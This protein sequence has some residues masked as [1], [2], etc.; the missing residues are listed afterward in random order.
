MERAYKKYSKGKVINVMRCLAGLEWRA[1][2][3]SLKCI[4][5]V[6]I[7]AIIDYGCVAYG[8]AA[9]SVIRTGC[10]LGSGAENLFRGSENHTSVCSSGRRRNATVAS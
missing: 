8:T 9:K 10:Y 2:V 7:W 5:I 4:N 6:L 1:D 3:A